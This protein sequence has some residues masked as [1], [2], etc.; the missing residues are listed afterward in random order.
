MIRWVI[1][2]LALGH[3]A[4]GQQLIEGTV[5]DK[6]TGKAIPFASL[7]IEG[8]SQGTSANLQGQFSLVVPDTFS[9]RVTCIGYE[10]SIVRSIDEAQVI[11]L[12]AIAT[13]LK[14]VYVFSKEINPKKNCAKSFC[15]HS[16]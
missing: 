15:Q 10:T 4:L 16:Q 8:T 6:E 13:Q 12:K 5:V 1:I 2:F 3:V 11:K 9:L 14:E 7:V